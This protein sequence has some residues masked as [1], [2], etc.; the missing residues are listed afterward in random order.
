MMGNFSEFSSS[1]KQKFSQLQD[2]KLNLSKMKRKNDI[3]CSA[4]SWLSIKFL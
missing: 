4:A 3:S 1:W 2:E